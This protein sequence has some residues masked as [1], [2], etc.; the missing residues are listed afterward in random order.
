MAA[1]ALCKGLPQNFTKVVM[2]LKGEHLLGD[3][4]GYFAVYGF[5]R[6]DE[7]E[8]GEKEH[9]LEYIN[10]FK[11][12]ITLIKRM[13]TVLIVG[14]DA[15][16]LDEAYA[17]AEKHVNEMEEIETRTRGKPLKQ[18]KIETRSAAAQKVFIAT[19]DSKLS[20]TTNTLYADSVPETLPDEGFGSEEG[21]GRQ[22]I[23]I[24]PFSARERSTRLMKKILERR[25]NSIRKPAV[26]DLCS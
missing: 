20:R 23:G 13:G 8:S 1:R 19:K 11:K 26:V 15:P 25:H 4:K 24:G 17:A 21:N 10:M 5:V 6:E 7:D 18:G 12:S 14:S 9:L 3:N 22:G 16:S 2:E